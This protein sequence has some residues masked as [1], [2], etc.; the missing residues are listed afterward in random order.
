MKS[1][2]AGIVRQGRIHQ[3]EYILSIQARKRP[4]TLIQG[5]KMAGW[6]VKVA[7]GCG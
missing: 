4:A 1:E 6:A 2:C 7:L 5:G 3:E